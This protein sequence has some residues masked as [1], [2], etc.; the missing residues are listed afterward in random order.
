VLPVFLV[1]LRIRLAKATTQ[2]Y[3]KILTETV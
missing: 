1:R 3:T 2:G